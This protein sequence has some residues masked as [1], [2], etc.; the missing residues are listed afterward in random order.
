M[1][2]SAVVRKLWRY[3]DVLRDDGM[4]YGDYTEQRTRLLFL[5]M[6]NVEKGIGQFSTPTHFGGE[7]H[8]LDTEQ[9]LE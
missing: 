6:A 4:N 3:C 7:G 8:S 2:S 9:V 1:A 5:K